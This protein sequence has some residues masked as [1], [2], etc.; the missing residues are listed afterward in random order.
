MREKES[1][2]DRETGTNTETQRQRQIETVTENKSKCMW[3]DYLLLT[4]KLGGPKALRTQVAKPRGRQREE[5]SLWIVK[6]S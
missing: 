5:G 3:L 1:D 2:R 4:Q 6:S